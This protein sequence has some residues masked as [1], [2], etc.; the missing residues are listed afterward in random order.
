MD[1]EGAVIEKRGSD[2][3][4]NALDCRWR[5]PGPAVICAGTVLDLRAV[6]RLA[7]IGAPM[8]VSPDYNPRVVRALKV[9]C[10]LTLSAVL[11]RE[12]KIY[13]VGDAGPGDFAR[14]MLPERP[15]SAHASTP[16]VSGSPRGPARSRHWS[17][18]GTRCL[19]EP[20]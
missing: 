15:A 14:D 4:M 13:A 17:P 16:P 12:T 8:V 7:E 20:F 11:P 1:A 18:P 10:M 2:N 19:C 3:G 6:D 5:R 9:A